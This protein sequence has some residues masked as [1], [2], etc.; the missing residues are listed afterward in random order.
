VLGYQCEVK[1]R[2]SLQLERNNVMKM[3]CGDALV[4]FGGLGVAGQKKYQLTQISR[5]THCISASYL[6][7]H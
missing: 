5:P 6:L 1:P 2:D 7:T 4:S 3:E